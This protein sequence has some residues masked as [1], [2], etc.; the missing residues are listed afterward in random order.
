MCFA[1]WESN[2]KKEVIATC[3]KCHEL[4]YKGDKFYKKTC[5]IGIA[6]ILNLNSPTDISMFSMPQKVTNLIKKNYY[7]K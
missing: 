1:D 5:S 2:K 6:W 3:D 7:L 4:I